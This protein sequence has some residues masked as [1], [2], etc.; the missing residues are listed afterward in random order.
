[1]RALWRCYTGAVLPAAGVLAGPAWW[2]AGR[3]LHRSIPASTA[4]HPLPELLADYRAAGLTGLRV[5]RLSLGG[6]VVIWG[7]RDGEVGA[8]SRPDAG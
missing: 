1:M 2:R 4:R 7:T 8:P 6:A 5:R 3:F